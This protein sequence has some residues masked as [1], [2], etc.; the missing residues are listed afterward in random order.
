MHRV[1]GDV[2][3][4]VWASDQLPLLTRSFTPPSYFIV[5]THKGHQ[6]G[7]HWLS[8]T[9]EEDGTG[10][11]FDS[12]GF[13]PDFNYYPRSIL[14][15]LENRSSKILYHNLQLQNPLSDAC[16]QHCVY[17][18]YHRACGLSFQQV[19]SLYDDDAIK[20]DLEASNFVKKFQRCI[21]NR[22]KF[23]QQGACSLETFKRRAML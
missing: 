9:L 8:L 6:P 19:L 14:Q 13:A 10:T 3:C 23:C 7:E 11:F 18:L 4:G 12:F 5:N 17:Y 22:S 20:N 16:G 21:R 2:F 1:L 15:F